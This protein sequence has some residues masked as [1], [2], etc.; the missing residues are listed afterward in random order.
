LREIFGQVQAPDRGPQA[1]RLDFAAGLILSL[2]PG[3][4]VDV[5]PGVVPDGQFAVD[6]ND[7]FAV[8]IF[9]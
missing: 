2:P 7:L 4:P 8:R 5:F 3:K 6:R 9:S 1:V